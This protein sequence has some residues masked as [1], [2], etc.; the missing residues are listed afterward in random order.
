MVKVLVM[1]DSHGAKDTMLDIISAENPNLIIHLGDY[2]QDCGAA[3][4]KFP[5][6]PLK[7]IRGNGD[8][9]SS[10]PVD[11]IFTLENRVF[12]A[13]H[14]HTHS[15]KSG[16]SRLIHHAKSKQAEVVLFGHTHIPHCDISEDFAL[17]NPGCVHPS[18]G[19]YAVLHLSESDFSC[20]MKVV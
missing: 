20:E 18:V 4:K 3:E 5:N 12:F 1:S 15:V 7:R 8:F 13:T 9:T 14:G 19:S 17:I 16:L 10:V 6:I 2:T 11:D